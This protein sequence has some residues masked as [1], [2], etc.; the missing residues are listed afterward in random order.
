MREIKIAFVSLIRSFAGISNPFSI[1]Y[2]RPASTIIP[3][4]LLQNPNPKIHKITELTTTTTRCP[5]ARTSSTNP[6]TSTLKT[7]SPSPPAQS[8]QL[9][10]HQH[11]TSQPHNPKLENHRITHSN[12]LR[13]G[14][15]FAIHRPAAGTAA[16][17]WQAPRR[18]SSL[19]LH[20]P[21]SITETSTK[22][23]MSLQRT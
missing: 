11:L 14:H 2:N 15:A 12:K 16:A 7:P 23:Y 21:K 17:P 22:L 5:I 20:D 8:S 1:A 4:K 18:S 19:S 13:G 3:P 9:N 6:Q 10:A